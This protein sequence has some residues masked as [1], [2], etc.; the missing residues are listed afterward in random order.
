MML[1]WDWAKTAT[2]AT[3]VFP[4]VSTADWR[5]TFQHH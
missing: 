3:G 2:M 4:E 1:S 5:R